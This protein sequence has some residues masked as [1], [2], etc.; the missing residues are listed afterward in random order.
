MRHAPPFDDALK[1]AVGWQCFFGE[2]RPVT[3]LERRWW[4]LC[5][6]NAGQPPDLIVEG[7]RARLALRYSLFSVLK[8]A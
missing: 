2:G 7:R 1:A 4:A 5:I 6:S 3:P 8:L